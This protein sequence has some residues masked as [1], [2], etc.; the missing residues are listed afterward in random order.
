MLVNSQVPCCAP[1]F[2]SLMGGSCAVLQGEINVPSI[3]AELQ[4]PNSDNTL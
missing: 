3:P 1:Q 4:L 2:L